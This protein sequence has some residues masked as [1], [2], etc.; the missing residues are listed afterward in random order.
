MITISDTI[1]SIVTI[2]IPN[3]ERHHLLELLRSDKYPIRVSTDRGWI[4]IY[5]DTTFHVNVQCLDRVIIRIPHTDKQELVDA[6]EEHIA[7]NG[8]LPLDHSFEAS[9]AN[10]VPQGIRDV[11]VETVGPIK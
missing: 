8:S 1:P 9:G 11:V 7:E 10:I 5:D 6:I 3:N 4:E 2:Q